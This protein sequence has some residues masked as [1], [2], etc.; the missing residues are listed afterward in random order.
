MSVID[1]LMSVSGGN[2][3]ASLFQHWL[4]KKYYS[5]TGEIKHTIILILR[6]LINI[7]IYFS[8][9]SNNVITCWLINN[10]S[11][12]SASPSPLHWINGHSSKHSAEHLWREDN[13]NYPCQTVWSHRAQLGP[14]CTY[15]ASGLTYSHQ[16]A[17]SALQGPIVHDTTIACQGTMVSFRVFGYHSNCMAQTMNLL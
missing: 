2:V 9:R 17:A 8:F 7:Y 10:S 3:I 1:N 14:P 15:S 11:L 4:K 16:K 12:T 6:Q 5:S 13:I